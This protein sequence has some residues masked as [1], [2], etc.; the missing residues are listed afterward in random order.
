MSELLALALPM[1]G[2]Q[3]SWVPVLFGG[4]IPVLGALAIGLIIYRAVRDSD[5]EDE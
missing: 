4:L 2:A 5:E 3:E 1:V